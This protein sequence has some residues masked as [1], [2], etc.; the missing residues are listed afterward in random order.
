[1]NKVNPKYAII[2]YKRFHDVEETEFE[3]R[4]VNIKGVEIVITSLGLKYK[5]KI[6]YESFIICADCVSVHQFSVTNLKLKEYNE[7]M[8][9]LD[10][11][12]DSY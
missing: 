1:M 10:G 8:E 4:T 11:K 7:I 9:G 12:I 6:L 5:D 2:E 3:K